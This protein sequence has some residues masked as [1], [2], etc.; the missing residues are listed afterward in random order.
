MVA[1]IAVIFAIIPESPWWLVSK[2]K[3]DK[4]A[5]ILKW[6]NGKVDGY[7]VD[8]QIVCF[9]FFFKLIGRD[10]DILQEI[11]TATVNEER[12]LAE[13]NAEEGSWAVFQG[14]NRIRFLIAAW[15]KIAQQ[16]VGLAVFNT[17]AT[18]FCKT[19]VYRL[20]FVVIRANFNSSPICR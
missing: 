9:F 2:G 11:M 3:I 16:L 5:K 12:I 14:R 15:P 10:I 8:E 20:I 17:Y 6:C 19:P 1:M 4:A 18:Y 13:R 7:S